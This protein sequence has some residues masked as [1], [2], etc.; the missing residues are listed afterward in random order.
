[1]C[2]KTL[3][4]DEIEIHSF[5]EVHSFVHSFLWTPLTVLRHSVCTQGKIMQ[6][7]AVNFGGIQ[8]LELFFIWGFLGFLLKKYGMIFKSPVATLVAV[9]D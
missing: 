2:N 1:M 7:I 4:V 8:R 6:H 3:H 5:I 9:S